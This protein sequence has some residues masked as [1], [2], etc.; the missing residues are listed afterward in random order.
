MKQRLI[1]MLLAFLLVFSAS[2]AQEIRVG[3]KEVLKINSTAFNYTKTSYVFC[4][5]Q[6]VFNSGSLGYKARARIDIFNDSETVFTGWSEEKT[7]AP[8]MRDILE[9]CWFE[10]NASGK[11]L[12][13]LRVYYANEILEKEG[14]EFNKIK[15]SSE[16]I[17]LIEDFRTYDNHVRFSIKPLK[18]VESV[19]VFPSDYPSS[20][21]FEQ[22]KI[23]KIEKNDRI[24]V[25]LPYKADFWFNHSVKINVVAE[26]GS[27]YSSKT[28]GLKKE[29]GIMKYINMLIDRIKV[30]FDL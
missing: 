16:D 12:G 27:Y 19:I 18:T 1:F 9:V 4:G 30:V 15:R 23:D 10:P 2:K 20:W 6:E 13:R 22:K 28:F 14:F 3:V 21:V 26:N 17:F 25:E 11:F 8:G 5:K 29:E 7:L 24:S